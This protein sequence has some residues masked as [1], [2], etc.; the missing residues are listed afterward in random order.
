MYFIGTIPATKEFE[1]G[2]AAGMSTYMFQS[3]MHINH[4]HKYSRKH[5][6]AHT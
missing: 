1:S 5:L 3:H 6:T 2:G 4:G